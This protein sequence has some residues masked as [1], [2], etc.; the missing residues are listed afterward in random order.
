[1]D[2]RKAFGLTEY[3]ENEVPR[4]KRLKQYISLKLAALG[5]PI[6]VGD[7]DDKF[8]DYATD[9]IKNYKEKNRLL[10]NYLCPA[11]QRI[12]DFIDSYLREYKE[13]IN[14]RI[15]S[16]TFTIDSHGIARMMSLPA[17]SSEFKSDIIYSYKIKQGVLHNPKNDRRTT[18]GVFHIVEGG[19]PIPDDKKA[20]P[21]KAFA[22]LL[23]CALNP[24]KELLTLPYTS[25]QEEKAELFVSLLLKPVVS[26]EVKGLSKEKRME[27]RFF[28]PGNLVSNLDFVESI[29]G[30]AGDPYLPENDSA[31]SIEGWTGHTDCIILAPHLVNCTKKEL[32]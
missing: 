24:P 17:D 21:K 18:E 23:L 32:G 3:G 7:S 26:P 14:I 9:L 20:V 5:Q 30:N 8:L 22:N 1:M 27:I 2:L 19:L 25:Q 12:Q 4:I 28:A 13:K 15:P 16:N 29:F 6:Y 31:L 10:S 11:D